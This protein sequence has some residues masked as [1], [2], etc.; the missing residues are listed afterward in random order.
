MRVRGSRFK[1]PFLCPGACRNGEGNHQV[2]DLV[3]PSQHALR[4]GPDSGVRGIYFRAT[5][6]AQQ[7]ELIK[8][9]DVRLVRWD[10]WPLNRATGPQHR[11]QGRWEEVGLDYFLIRGYSGRDQFR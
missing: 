1:S 11:A 10:A 5:P 4:W 7:L 9:G 2:N 3:M 8:L 6:V